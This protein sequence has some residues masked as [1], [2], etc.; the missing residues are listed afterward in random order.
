MD[1]QKKDRVIKEASK[2]CL[3]MAKLVF[4]GIILAGIMQT[5]IKTP[6]LLWWA[7]VAVLI[8]ALSGFGLLLLYKNDQP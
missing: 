8:L 1:K 2:F 7:G 4:A 5:G 3:D 6:V